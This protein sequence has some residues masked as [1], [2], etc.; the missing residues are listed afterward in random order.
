MYKYILLLILLILSITVGCTCNVSEGN[1]YFDCEGNLIP[2]TDVPHNLGSL[3]T[4]WDALYVNNIVGWVPVGS[5]TQ[6]TDWIF[7]IDGVTALINS[8]VLV[9]DLDTDRWISHDSNTFLGID[10]AGADTLAHT[11]GL[12]GYYNTGYGNFALYNITL[13]GQNTAIGCEAATDITEG[14]YNTAVGYKALAGVTTG[15]GNTAIGRL[16][17]SQVGTGNYNTVVGNDALYQGTGSYN[18]AIGLFAGHENT[19]GNYNIFIGNKAG[20]NELGSNKLYIDNSDTATPLIYGDFTAN[21]T[22]INGDLTAN[23]NFNYGVDAGASDSY[24]CTITGITEY[25]A[26]MPIYFNANT[27]NTGACTINVNILGAISLKV[28]GNTT[29]PEDNWILADQIVHCVYDGTVFQILNP[30]STP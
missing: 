6:N 24:T 13:G 27:A 28:K 19:V 29:D 25:K 16:A 4:P 11:A 7:T 12:E 14:N 17:L 22:V 30:D 20:Y 10:V 5:H 15:N 2:C 18:T 9:Y 1:V 21:D 8:G 26:G 23:G 3:T